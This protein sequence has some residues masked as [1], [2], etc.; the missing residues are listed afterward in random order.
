[1]VGPYARAGS[2]QAVLGAKR[3]LGSSAGAT[4]VLGYHKSHADGL[5]HQVSARQG[6]SLVDNDTETNRAAFLVG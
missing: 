6:E 5:P 2:A 3:K 1:M 4:C